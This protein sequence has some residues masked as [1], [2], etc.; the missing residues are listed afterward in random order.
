MEL[1]GSGWKLDLIGYRSTG[2]HYVSPKN[3]ET[4]IRR[5][6]KT[7]CYRCYSARLL[8]Y[9]DRPFVRTSKGKRVYSS[10]RNGNYT[11]FPFSY[12]DVFF[13]LLVT[14]LEVSSRLEANQHHVDVRCACQ[15]TEI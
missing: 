5:I 2:R 14:R 11:F 4:S 12:M 9:V 15:T 10:G 3:S 8:E 13:H 6:D 1:K 7:Y